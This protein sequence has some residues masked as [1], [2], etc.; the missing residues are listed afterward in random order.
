[1]ILILYG[2]VSQPVD[3]RGLTS[4]MIFTAAGLAVFLHG[5]SSVPLV[6]AYSRWY[7]AQVA[8]PPSASEAKPTTMSRLRRQPTPEQTEPMI[9][10]P[11]PSQ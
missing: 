7:A 1:M 3:K 8:E 9:A 5:L 11:G 4:A 2:A 6:A 10:Q